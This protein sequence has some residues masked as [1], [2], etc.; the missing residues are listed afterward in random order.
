MW[1]S[2]WTVRT[3]VPF[4]ISRLH[5]IRTVWCMYEWGVQNIIKKEII[6]QQSVNYFRADNPKFFLAAGTRTC[7]RTC[8]HVAVTTCDGMKQKNLQKMYWVYCYFVFQ[9]LHVCMCT[10]RITH[11]DAV[12][13]ITKLWA[14]ESGSGVRSVN[15]KPDGVRVA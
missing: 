15:V 5:P 2:T 9:L 11:L 1:Y 6:R 7:T 14:D 8:V 13:V 12:Q 3:Q 10:C 4:A